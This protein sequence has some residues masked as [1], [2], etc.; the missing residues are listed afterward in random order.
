[1]GLELFD[2]TVAKVTPSFRT[3]KTNFLGN[4]N[5]YCSYLGKTKVKYFREKG[6]AA[7]LVCPELSKDLE[8]VPHGV[9]SVKKKTEI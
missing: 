7:D 5:V 3:R 6:N 9:S 2:H 4:L 1:M 8:R